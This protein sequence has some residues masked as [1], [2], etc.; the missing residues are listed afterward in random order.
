MKKVGEG[1]WC[2]EGMLVNSYILETG[3]NTCVLVDCGFPGWGAK[4]RDELQQIQAGECIPTAIVLTHGHIDHIGAARELAE[5]YNIPIFAHYL[6]LPYLDGRS[7]YPPP[8]PTVGGFHAMVSRFLSHG[9]SQLGN[10][11]TMLPS[12]DTQ[13][14]GELPEILPQWRWLFT[15]GH[16]PGHIALYRQS[17][18]TLL[19]GDALE[20]TSMDSWIESLLKPHHLWRGGTPFTCDWEAAH[21]SVRLLA[22]LQPHAIC[23][24]HGSPIVDAH[25]AQELGCLAENFPIPRKGRYSRTPAHTGADG[26][27][28]LPEQ[29]FDYL[30]LA[31]VGFGLGALGLMSSSEA[32]GESGAHTHMNPGDRLMFRAVA[33]LRGSEYSPLLTDTE[34]D[35]S[36]TTAHP[37]RHFEGEHR[38]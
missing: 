31:L 23:C 30:P 21:G 7:A 15:P 37:R 20:T 1:V 11:L 29:P 38:C 14:E 34:E 12:S 16:S 28:N 18:R 27:I 32:H 26:V 25:V 5:D 2:V 9:P 33:G 4:I 13:G 10:H 6:E 22:R 8:D 24:G 36:S 35:Y 3:P 19:A 17:D